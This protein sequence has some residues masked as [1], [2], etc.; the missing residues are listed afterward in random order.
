IALLKTRGG[1]ALSAFR[2]DK[3]NARV[4]ALSPGLAVASARFWHLVETDGDLSDA[5]RATLDRLLTYG[6]PGPD[7]DAARQVVLVVP[8]LGTISP[9]SSKATDIVHQCGLERVRRVERGT[10]YQLEGDPDPADA[11][12]A[13]HDRMT[14]TVLASLDEADALFR[15]VA[16]RPLAEVNVAGLGRAAIEEANLALGLALAPDEIDYLVQYF[17]GAGRNPTDVELTM[18]AQANSEHCRH[19]IFNASWIIDGEPQRQSLFGMIRE[20]HR[21]NPQGTV[22][23]YA[24][25][26]AVMEG[27]TVRR[28]FADPRTGAYG[29][30]ED[31]THTLMKVET[32]NH[33]TAISPF[34]G[35]ATGS[36]GEIR[37]E[38]ATGRGAKPKAGLCGFSVSDL[39]IPGYVQ[40]W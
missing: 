7:P 21:A 30:H 17:T 3:L 15:H 34:P 29:F 13:L 22:V 14:E 8:R 5:E 35:A 4:R 28:F 18:F 1:Q 37:D 23:A 24:D 20:T 11:L 19:K 32:H 12:A 27:R 31:A 2:L 6:P 33:P 26:A 25:N 39:K 16:P 36:G 38:G 9:W 40:P 10:A